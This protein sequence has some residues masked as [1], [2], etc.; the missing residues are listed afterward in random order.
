MCNRTNISEL[1]ISG[2]IFFAS[3]FVLYG[4]TLFLI[5]RNVVLINRMEKQ[6]CAL[7][8]VVCEGEY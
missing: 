2:K 1:S 8:A 3:L 6:A 7:E 5:I 4:I